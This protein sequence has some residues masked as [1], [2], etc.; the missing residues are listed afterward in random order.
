[1]F[2]ISFPFEHQHPQH[3][4]PNTFPPNQC[5]TH[6]HRQVMTGQGHGM[7]RSHSVGK[8]FLLTYKYM[9]SETSAPA[10]PGYYLYIRNHPYVRTYVNTY[11]QNIIYVFGKVI[12]LHAIYT[13]I[14]CTFYL[15]FQSQECQCGWRR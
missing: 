13:Y 11:I 5:I 14:K 15:R 3:P 2:R 1:M 8:S 4:H 12:S 7:P 9:P 6:K 10:W